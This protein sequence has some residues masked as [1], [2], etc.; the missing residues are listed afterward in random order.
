MYFFNHKFL[1]FVIIDQI[2]SGTKIMQKDSVTPVQYVTIEE[3]Y[4]GQRIDNF[5]VTKLKGLPKT[6]LYRLL[7]KGEVR[8]NKKRTPP[9]YRLQTGDIIRLPPMQLEEK[10]VPTTPG[11]RSIEMLTDRVLYEDKGLMIINKPSGIPVH[12]GSSVS[13]GVIEILRTMYPKLPHLEL[14]HRLDAD[15]SGC[16]I[17][18]KK[19]GILKEI[20]ELLRQGQVHKVYLTLT[21]G[22]WSKPELKVDASLRKS[23]MSNGERIVK[24]DKEGKESLTVF[25]PIQNFIGASLLE[26]TLHTGRT[27]QIR[28]H[29]R[30]RSHPIAGDEKY[31]DKDFNKEMRQKGLKRLFLHSHLIEFTI[32]STGQQISVRAPLE[33]DLQNCLN[34]LDFSA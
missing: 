13:M 6:R 1:F 16:L 32:P 4:A 29:A 20:H 23:Y 2:K 22:H 30:H 19:R 3:D 25:E 27:H 31:G 33:P 9:S 11:R 12:G 26:A 28:V 14:A 34:N 10:P 8:V 18:A 21:K 15:T 7:R 24:V 5:L 17:L